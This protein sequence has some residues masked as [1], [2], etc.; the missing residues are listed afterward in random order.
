MVS[1]PPVHHEV[2]DVAMW[3]STGSGRLVLVQC[4]GESRAALSHG[5][6]GR[7]QILCT[8]RCG[9]GGAPMTGALRGHLFGGERGITIADTCRTTGWYEPCRDATRA[10]QQDAF[11]VAEGV[12]L[13]AVASDNEQEHGQEGDHRLRSGIDDAF[14]ISVA[15]FDPRVDVVAIT[16][17]AGNV[18]A[19]Q[20][21]RNVQAIIERLDPPRFPRRCRHANGDVCR[22]RQSSDAR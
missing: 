18:P 15:L 8:S 3:P 16:A 14:A 22:Y 13:A 9:D 12:E 5:Y 17:T 11:R 4:F 6:P 20:A 10:S 2:H 19:E 1:S 7:T 21:S